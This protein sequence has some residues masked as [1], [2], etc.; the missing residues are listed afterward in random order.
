MA[1]AKVDAG[2][3]ATINGTV[4]AQA[5]SA[6]GDPGFIDFS[7]GMARNAG[8]TVAQNIIAPGGSTSGSGQSISLAGCRP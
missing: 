2:G 5:L 8:L 6:D 7:S 4:S 3:A 1:I